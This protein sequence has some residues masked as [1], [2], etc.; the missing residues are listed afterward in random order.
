MSAQAGKSLNPADENLVSDP[1]PDS[2][3]PRTLLQALWPR[4]IE[5]WI[6]AVIA[7]FFLIRIVGSQ[8]A[9][10]IFARLFHPHA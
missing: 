9:Q 10:R 2:Q 4:F 7:V 5:L 1:Q 3:H 8:T 6:A